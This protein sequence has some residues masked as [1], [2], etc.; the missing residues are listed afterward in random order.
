MKRIW[1]FGALA[2]LTLVS[3][4]LAAA[5]QPTTAAGPHVNTERM[6]E[7]TRVLASDAF[8]GRAPGT[9]G[10]DGRSRT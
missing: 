8:Q 5:A 10:E 4:S 3:A 6:S 9:P 2:R 1:L 7:I